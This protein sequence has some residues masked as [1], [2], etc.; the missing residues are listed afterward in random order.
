MYCLTPERAGNVSTSRVGKSTQRMASSPR[1]SKP[2][3]RRGPSV[4]KS[5]SVRNAKLDTL[6]QAAKVT[7][8]PAAQSGLDLENLLP[9]GK[10]SEITGWS[11]GH[12][13]NQRSAGTG[14]RFYRLNGGRIL[15]A[16]SD[17][18]RFIA[19]QLVG[20]LDQSA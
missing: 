3:K 2:S 1:E 9:P 15:Y 17:V 5:P 12:L 20:T 11:L 10:V 6:A 7:L 13:A 14:I 4:Q 16:R 8:S 19:S 18:E